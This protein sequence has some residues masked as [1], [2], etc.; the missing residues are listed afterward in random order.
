LTSEN[1]MNQKMHKISKSLT[2]PCPTTD[3]NRRHGS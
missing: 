2:D 1:K 3:P